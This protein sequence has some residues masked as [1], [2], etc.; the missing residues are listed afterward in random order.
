M[1]TLTITIEGETP[2][3][4]AV[5]LDEIKNLVSDG[6]TAGVGFEVTGERE[7]YETEDAG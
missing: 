2:E 7:E 5:Q 3:V 6:N 4:L 1:L